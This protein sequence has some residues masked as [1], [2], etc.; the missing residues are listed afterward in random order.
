MG[1]GPCRYLG[2]A[3]S[4]LWGSLT[5]AFS[6]FCSSWALSWADLPSSQLPSPL[7]SGTPHRAS[8]PQGSWRSK[9]LTGPASRKQPVL[10]S[11]LS[12]LQFQPLIYVPSTPPACPGASP[13]TAGIQNWDPLELS[14]ASW[15]APSPTSEPSPCCLRLAIPPALATGLQPG[16]AG[17]AARALPLRSPCLRFS[18]NA[19][20]ADASTSLTLPWHCL[21]GERQL[22][23]R[24]MDRGPQPRK[25]P[26]QWV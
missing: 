5:L 18:Q 20:P 24:E 17:S 23:H 16:P 9:R 7:R 26:G 2:R 1:Q 14:L 11:L 4:S 3:F 10:D 8:G 22:T 13:E 25:L 6:G 15:R 12:Q 21:S 19:C